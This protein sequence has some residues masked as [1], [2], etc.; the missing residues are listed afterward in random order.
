[1]DMGTKA[2]K[3]IRPWHFESDEAWTRFND[4]L[5]ATP[6]YTLHY[7]ILFSFL[8]LSLSVCLCV[9]VC[10]LLLFRMFWSRN[11]SVWLTSSLS[12]SLSVCVCVCVCVCVFVSTCTRAAFQ[13]GVKMAD[14]RKKVLGGGGGG[15]QKSKGKK[16]VDKINQQLQK[17]NA[18]N[19]KRPP[20][21]K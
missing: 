5:E 9:C 12:L 18:F 15:K 14:G 7:S 13:F 10:A 20:P 16:N 2:R 21:A 11:S 19:F 4:Q 3:K 8:S 1:M 6:K 17:I